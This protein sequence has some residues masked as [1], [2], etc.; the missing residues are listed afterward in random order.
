MTRIEQELVLLRSKF[1]DAALQ[2]QWVLLP[3]YPVPNPG[4]GADSV[5]VAFP[6]PAAYPAQKPYAFYV[7]PPLRVGASIPGNATE[8]SDPV[9]DGEWTKFSWDCQDWSPAAEVAGGSNLLHWAL[10]F[11]ERLKDYS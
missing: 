11:H 1:P 7:S 6:I 10:S 9:F 8:A 3:S 5:K 4:W 2:G